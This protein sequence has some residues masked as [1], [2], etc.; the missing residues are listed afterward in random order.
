MLCSLTMDDV[1]DEII[2]ENMSIPKTTTGIAKARSL[3]FCGAII[4]V[5]GAKLDIDH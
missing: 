3:S 2:I 5:P 1:I 4:E